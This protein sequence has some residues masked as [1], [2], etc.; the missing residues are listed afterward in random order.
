MQQAL[1][2]VKDRPDLAR[3]PKSGAVLVTAQ[4]PEAKANRIKRQV[5]LDIKKEIE[6]LKQAVCGLQT[7]INDIKQHL[8]G[9]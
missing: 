8:Q 2:Q 7:C 5:I 1:I 9:I 6:D 3:D 4:S